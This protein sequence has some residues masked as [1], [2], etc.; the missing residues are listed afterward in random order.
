LGKDK[1]SDSGDE[2]KCDKK[3]PSGRENG[4]HLKVVMGEGS[5]VQRVRESKVT[6]SFHE[7]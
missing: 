3:P 5:S 6:E 2:S 4:F 7:F 1:N